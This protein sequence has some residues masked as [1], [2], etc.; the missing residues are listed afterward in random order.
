MRRAHERVCRW[1]LLTG[2]AASD[3]D[4][5]GDGPE[6]GADR[7]PGLWSARHGRAGNVQWHPVL[8]SRFVT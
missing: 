1:L 4:G 7:A 2:F 8:Q 5:A 6:P 3:Q